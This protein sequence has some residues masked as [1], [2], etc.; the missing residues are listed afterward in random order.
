MRQELPFVEP[1]HRVR[2]KQTP[3]WLAS[4]SVMSASVHARQHAP[5]HRAGGRLPTGRE[6]MADAAPAS[7]VA[8]VVSFALGSMDVSEHEKSSRQ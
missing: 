8:L 1:G 6:G 5:P 7:P 4:A 2:T 3:H